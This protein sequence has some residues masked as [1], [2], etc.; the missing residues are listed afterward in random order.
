MNATILLFPR[1]RR[2]MATRHQPPG[3]GTL[4]ARFALLLAG[5]AWCWALLVLAL[6]W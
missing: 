1:K 6:G 3:L 5:A 2:P 4:L